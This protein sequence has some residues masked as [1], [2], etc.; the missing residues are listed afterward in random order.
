MNVWA[1][2]LVWL[3]GLFLLLFAIYHFE[4]IAHLNAAATFR[5]MPE[6][7]AET[8]ASFVLGVYLSLLFIKGPSRPNVP[9]LVCVFLPS[10][11]LCFIIPITVGTALPIP[12]WMTT[13]D[14]HGFEPVVS[15][16]SLMIA[17]FHNRR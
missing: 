6:F 14:A 12:L 10:T 15:G 4:R 5:V 8:L 13:L 11:I 7:W 1:R 17:L 3:I 9:L 16:F 2:Y